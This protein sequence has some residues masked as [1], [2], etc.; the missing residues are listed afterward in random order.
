MGHSRARYL[1]AQS[2]VDR[3]TDARLDWLDAHADESPPGAR[4]FAI[5]SEHF[6]FSHQWNPHSAS[7]DQMSVQFTDGGAAAILF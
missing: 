6:N 5:D 7:F 1:T 2:T 3:T 4:A